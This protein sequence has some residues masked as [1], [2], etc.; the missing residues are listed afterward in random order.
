MR[1]KRSATPP[2][3]A[4]A[5]L[6]LDVLEAAEA[7]DVRDRFAHR[8][9]RQRL[10]GP[11]L[12]QIEER[13][14]RSSARFSTS[15]WMS[16]DRTAGVLTRGR[17]RPHG[18]TAQ[19]SHQNAHRR[20]AAPTGRRA[21]A[22]QNLWRTRK[23]SAKVLSPSWVNTQPEALVLVVLEDDDL[24]AVAAA[25]AERARK[26]QV[27]A[28]RDALADDHARRRRQRV[29]LV[30]ERRRDL[31]ACRRRT[32]RRARGRRASD[33]GLTSSRAMP[34]RNSAVSD[35][36]AALDRNDRSSAS[37]QV[38]VLAEEQRD[39][40]HFGQRRIGVERRS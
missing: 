36:C 17:L 34:S 9:Q 26:R 20:P 27:G 18:R 29:G 32:P 3:G 6:D 37:S 30:A 38:D 5:G 1:L 24:I 40:V 21:G 19:A 23:S 10:T 14:A 4:C 39:D 8:R 11:H 35:S 12:D 31:H 25:R 33:I 7:V 28:I 16:L 13:R 2:P 22:H 15:S